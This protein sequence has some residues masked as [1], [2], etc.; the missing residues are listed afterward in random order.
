MVWENPYPLDPPSLKKGRKYVV[1]KKKKKNQ[2]Y[3]TITTIYA[4][5]TQS[6]KTAFVKKKGHKWVRTRQKR[7][8]TNRDLILEGDG[9]DDD[10]DGG[11]LMTMIIMRMVFAMIMIMMMMLM[12]IIMM[13]MLVTINVIILMLTGR[14]MTMTSTTTKMIARKIVVVIKIMILPLWGWT[15]RPHLVNSFPG[16]APSGMY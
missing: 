1:L 6:L 7:S 5:L 2:C 9:G 10:C 12:M 8:K 14:E 16:Y 13:M 3:I 4:H 11:E 15:W